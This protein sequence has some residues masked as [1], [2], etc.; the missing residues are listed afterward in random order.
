[1]G[2]IKE[3]YGKSPVDHRAIF[4]ET[5]TGHGDSLRYI[6]KYPFNLIYSIDIDPLCINSM[7]KEFSNDHRVNLIEGKSEEVLPNICRKHPEPILFWLDAHFPGSYSTGEVD[8]RERDLNIRLPLEIELGIISSCRDASDDII[9]I[10][11]LRIYEDG[12][13]ESGNWDSRVPLGGNGVDF[14]YELFSETHIIT[15][16]YRN[17]GYIELVPNNYRGC[18]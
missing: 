11:D 17:H 10:D 15:K 9:L 16:S 14:I 18:M 1:M 5:G 2:T 4:V 12:D 6:S 3:F 13:F 7:S 8:D